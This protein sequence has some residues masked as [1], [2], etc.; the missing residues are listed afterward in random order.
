MGSDRN[1]GEGENWEFENL[2][3]LIEEDRI[4]REIENGERKILRFHKELGDHVV[5]L[6]ALGTLP[7]PEFSL[8]RTSWIQKYSYLFS[9]TEM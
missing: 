7:V 4:W 1:G 3:R 2:G 9:S 8:Q 6:R 5:N